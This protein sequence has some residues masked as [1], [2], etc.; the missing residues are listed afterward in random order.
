MPQP[1]WGFYVVLS[2]VKVESEPNA[3]TRNGSEKLPLSF[4]DRDAYIPWDSSFAANKII[5]SIYVEH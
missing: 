4:F 3:I 2:V 5:A 1:V